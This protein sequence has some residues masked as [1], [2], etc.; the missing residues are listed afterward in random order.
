MENY[1]YCI[2]WVC[3]LNSKFE[4]SLSCLFLFFFYCET[5]ELFFHF[6]FLIKFEV[7][8]FSGLWQL[9]G[10][11]FNVEMGLNEL[12]RFYRCPKDYGGVEN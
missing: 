4:L 5:F 8:H 11:Y 12:E 7:F 10:L 2:V 3:I 9:Q 1:I 6:C